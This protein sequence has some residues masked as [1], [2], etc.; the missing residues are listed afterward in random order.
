MTLE[1]VAN[2]SPLNAVGYM[3]ALITNTSAPQK[4]NAITGPATS[5]ARG[6]HRRDL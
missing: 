4:Q 2:A 5:D 6:I 3:S 1:S